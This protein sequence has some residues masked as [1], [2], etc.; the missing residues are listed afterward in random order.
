MSS[1]AFEETMTCSGWTATMMFLPALCPAAD[2][3][4]IEVRAGGFERFEKPV[5]VE[6]RERPENPVQVVEV[7]SG[8][9]VVNPTVPFQIDGAGL[10]FL[11]K[12]TTPGDAIRRF[13]VREAKNAPAVKALLTLTDNVEWQGQASYKIVTQ[14]ATF[15]Y[16]KAGAGFASMIDQDGRDWIGYRPLGGPDGKYRGIPNLVNPEGHF[17]P[18]ETGCSSRLSNAGP[19]RITIDSESKD[20]KWAARWDIFPQY[21]RLTVLRAPRAYWFLYEGSLAGTFDPEQQYIVRSGGQR[22]PATERW[23]G[24]IEGP[25][26]LYFSDTRI[27][28]ALFLV[29]HQDDAAIDSYWPMQG[30]MT[31]FGFGRLKLDASMDATPNQFT[32]GFAEDASTAP[33][34]IDSA[35]RDL[36]V[37]AR[38]AE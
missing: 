3:I 2:R 24:D 31:V 37:K 33:K 28:R 7:D 29:H 18:G 16:H 4:A 26:W 13:E 25:E 11:M 35:F 15:H 30:Q 5:E 34:T 8:G 36:V 21:A 10:V 27:H 17:H 12:G 9:R 23:D 19:L 14:Y 20:K 32:I 22:T 6:L 38:T 1:W